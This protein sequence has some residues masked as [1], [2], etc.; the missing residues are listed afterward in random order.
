M[1]HPKRLLIAINADEFVRLCLGIACF[2]GTLA[3][4][5]IVSPH[6]L[7]WSGPLRLVNQPGVEL[8]IDNAYKQQL[9]MK[10]TVARNG[11]Y[12]RVARRALLADL[13]RSRRVTI[14]G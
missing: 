6:S 4:P 12:R 1:H 9:A 8:S 10:K 7:L 13:I 3:A 11:G 14:A 2:I 5:T